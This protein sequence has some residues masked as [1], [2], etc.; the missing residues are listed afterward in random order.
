MNHQ[1]ALRLQATEKYV[2]GELLGAQRDMFEMHYFN[3]P[4][5]ALDLLSAA[6]F[7]D[8]AREIFRQEAI[9]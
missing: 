7:V 1:D 5:C 2:L 4:E 8:T 3:C 6:T 9:R